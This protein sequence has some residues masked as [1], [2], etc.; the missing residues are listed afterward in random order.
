MFT[1]V[2]VQKESISREK[3]YNT[4]LTAS[5]LKSGLMAEGKPYSRGDTL[6]WRLSNVKNNHVY[7]QGL[8]RECLPKST[9]CSG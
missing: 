1:G 6:R 7:Q 8:A 4:I 2:Y 9:I 5:S 3:A